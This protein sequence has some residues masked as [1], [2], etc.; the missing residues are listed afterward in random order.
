VLLALS[1]AAFALPTVL[2]VSTVML[3]VLLAAVQAS[4]S[5]TQSL[6]TQYKDKLSKEAAES[7][8]AMAKACLAANANVVQWTDARPL[9]PN[10]DCTGGEPSVTCPASSTDASCYVLNTTSFRTKFSVGVTV[11]GTPA[12]TEITSMGIADEVRKTSGTPINRLTY[13]IRLNVSD[14]SNQRAY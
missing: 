4:V 11:S 13:T 2:I 3:V 14:L 8:I 5:V 1:Q 7:G 10:T 12:I 9:K 6:D